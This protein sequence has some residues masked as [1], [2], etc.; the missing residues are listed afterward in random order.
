MPFPPHALDD[1]RESV[2][3]HWLSVPAHPA[4]STGPLAAYGASPTTLLLKGMGPFLA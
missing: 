4:D 1:H 3:T 2:A